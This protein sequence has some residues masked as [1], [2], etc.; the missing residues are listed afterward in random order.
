MIRRVRAGRQ[1]GRNGLETVKITGESWKAVSTV[2]I[3]LH[4]HHFVALF[5]DFDNIL[6]EERLSMRYVSGCVFQA[7][8]LNG[9][10][11]NLRA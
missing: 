1:P 6:V 7:L 3:R 11:C 8:E 2:P 5:L 9:G 10:P 4:I